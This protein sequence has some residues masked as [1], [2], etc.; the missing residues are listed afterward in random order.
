MDTKIWK[1][2]MIDGKSYLVNSEESDLGKF[3][4]SLLPQTAPG[5]NMSLFKCAKE[6][7]EKDIAKFNSVVI[8]G[9]KVCSVE[10]Y[11]V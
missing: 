8:L 4:K 1:I 5:E 9:S 3:T 2:N 11:V 7:T 6:Y 10:Y